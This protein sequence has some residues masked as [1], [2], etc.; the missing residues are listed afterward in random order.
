MLEVLHCLPVRQRIEYT[1]AS[2]VWQCQLGIAPIY[3]IDL[4]RVLQVVAPYA[5][6]E[7]GSSQSRL[8]VPLSCK[9]ALF[10]L[11][12]RRCGIASLLSCTS[13]VGRFSTH[14]IV[15]K[16]TSIPRNLTLTFVFDECGDRGGISVMVGGRMSLLERALC[17]LS[18]SL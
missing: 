13:Y 4:C 1:V 6:L 17:E 8:L 2:L 10:V 5:L 7:G 11:M 16:L 12:A 9:S 18:T 3:L 14:S 15:L